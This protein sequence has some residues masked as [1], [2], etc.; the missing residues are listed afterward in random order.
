MVSEREKQ[1]YN[2]Y[3][4]ATR[5]AKNQPTK[6][7]KDFS[8]LKDQDF[9]SLKKL[10]GFFKKHTHINKV[11]AGGIYYPNISSL[12]PAQANNVGLAVNHP[13][14]REILIDSLTKRQFEILVCLAKGMSNKD[15]AADLFISENTVKTHLKAVMLELSCSNRTEAGVLA[16]KLGLLAQ[17]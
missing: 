9:V 3:L 11:L 10:S 16:E 4:Y 5:S 6:F 17:P 7:R 8:K 13:Q 12:E 2:S 14:N 15:I 1:I